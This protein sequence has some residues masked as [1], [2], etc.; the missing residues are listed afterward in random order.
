M[1]AF[2]SAKVRLGSILR[3][4][5][6]SSFNYSACAARPISRQTGYSGQTR[7][8]HSTIRT[9]FASLWQ[10]ELLI[11]RSSY[12]SCTLNFYSCTRRTLTR[13][14]RYFQ[15]HWSD[16]LPACASFIS[17]CD[18]RPPAVFYIC[19]ACHK[20]LTIPLEI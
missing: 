16:L 8:C 18:M 1:T 11:T 2:W 13:G 6:Q 9:P 20:R 4:R 15:L 5:K 12:G 3:Q 14:M 19:L 17:M 7:L 10:A